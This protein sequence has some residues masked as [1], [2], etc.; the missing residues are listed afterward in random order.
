MPPLFPKVEPQV[1]DQRRA[2]C[3]ACPYKRGPFC[4][5]CS[6]VLAVKIP[7]AG[8]SCPAGKW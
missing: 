1:R 6:C 3:A 8:Q 2:L 5:L 4:A 7:F